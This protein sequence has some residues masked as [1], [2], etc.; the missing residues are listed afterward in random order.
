[1]GQTKSDLGL[2]KDSVCGEE[3]GRRAK[4]LC[5]GVGILVMIPGITWVVPENSLYLE[6]RD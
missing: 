3:W 1:M 5:F 2:H 6:K 4:P